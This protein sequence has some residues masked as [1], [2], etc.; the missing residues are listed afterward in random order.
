M[1]WMRDAGP[2]VTKALDR[3]THV[4]AFARPQRL[5]PPTHTSAEELCERSWGRQV[6]LGWT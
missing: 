1:A 5:Y 4:T 6:G 2:A 3:P